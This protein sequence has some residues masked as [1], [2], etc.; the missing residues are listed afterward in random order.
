MR[1]LLSVGLILC[2]LLAGTA[3]FAVTIR[4]VVGIVAD[5]TIQELNAGEKGVFTIKVRNAA[6]TVAQRVKISIDGEHPF[7]SDVVNLNK[8]MSYLNP[9]K[10]VEV[11]FDVVVSP[12]AESK[13]Y[14]FDIVF[15]Y[16]NYED[17]TFRET[18]KVFLK[19]N[20]D[21][22][23]PIIAITGSKM[24]NLELSEGDEG[25]LIVNLGN[26]GTVKAKD[27]RVNISGFSNEGVLLDNDA[28][29]KV[30]DTIEAKKN[31]LLYFNV[32]AGSDVKSGTFPL[33][34]KLNYKDEFGK[35]YERSGIVYTTLKG[36][37]SAADGTVKIE[38][39]KYPTKVKPN[40]DFNITFDLVNTGKTGAVSA[41]IDLAYAPEFITKS[42]SKAYARNLEAG[43]KQTVTFK[44][45]AKS[46]TPMESYHNY[47]NVKYRPADKPEATQSELQEYAGIFV[48]S[49]ETDAEG[50][51]PKLII[52]N[53]EYGGEV[54]YA[55]E[56]YTLDLY[57]K[58]TSSRESTKN[59]KVT[60]TSEE[61]V[62]TP[63]DSS[64][65]FF[66]QSI[67][68]GQ[69]K[70]HSIKL[71]TKID[72]SVKIYPVT[73]KMEYE[74]S[75]GKGYDEK[76]NP[77]AESE[78][79]S[80]AVA[81][82]VRLETADMVVPFDAQANTPFYIE[83]EFYNMGK[84]TMYNMM[85]KFDAEGLQTN[86]GS[87]FVGNFDAG[88]SEYYSAQVTAMEPGTYEGKLVYSF[89]D[90]LGTISTLEKPFTVSVI[91][92]QMPT[93]DGSME[94]FPPIDEM[95]DEK[96]FPWKWVIIGG[97]A[98]LAVIVVI[99]LRVRKKKRIQREL[100][101]LDE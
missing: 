68:P 100:E 6:N 36:K 35:S 54:V 5:E 38:N 37:D 19:V 24:G 78:A 23:E 90:A 67:G 93:D 15:E 89:E 22:V 26:T 32:K 44:M 34:I 63:V 42:G 84:S 69:I 3:S 20:N 51:R 17:E 2:L 98:L 11:A 64:S 33:T 59:I 31:E 46:D 4:P 9:N 85:V 72:A 14:E 1:K 58:N 66:I 49:S 52:N 77:Y 92:M 73:V 70:H 74:D 88:R 43:E 95:P 83:Q 79:L 10:T 61:N 39:L 71:K 41:E 53:Y 47:I 21:R 60:I 40:S 16:Q 48:N 27:M 13:V 7:R 57:I 25:S 76:N 82:P 86:E 97:S 45:M 75:S 12:T 87:Y 96:G 91:E 30:I 56:D 81:Q 50:S 94:E 29:T 80:V 28:D 8:T 18:Q 99:V 65:S 101:A 55:G 62:F